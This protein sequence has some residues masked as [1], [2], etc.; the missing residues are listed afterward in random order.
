MKITARPLKGDQFD[1]ECEPDDTVEQL[2]QKIA[3]AHPEFPVEQ[4]K[5]IFC[6]KILTDAMLVKAPWR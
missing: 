3:A 6:G 4:Q 5:L 1:I 2:K